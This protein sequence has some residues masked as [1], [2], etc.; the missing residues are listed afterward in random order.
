MVIETLVIRPEPVA[1][2]VSA[3]YWEGAAQGELRVQ[4]CNACGNA[5][6]PPNV[7]CER[8]QSFDLAYRVSAGRGT[9]YAKTV[10]HQA[11]HP[12]FTEDVPLTLCLVDLDDA[13]GVRL[14][15]NLVD[16]D[17]DQV[18]TGAALEVRFVARGNTV[19]PQFTLAGN[20]GGK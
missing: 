2:D 6:F 9:L 7:I 11:F 20:G 15:T 4:S 13:P 14:L 16:V 19:L 18:E 12:A 1:D 3:F 10:L 5:Q 17:P 8:C